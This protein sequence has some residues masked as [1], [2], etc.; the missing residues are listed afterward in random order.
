MK[1]TG[2]GYFPISNAVRHRV[3][4]E[5]ASPRR[6]SLERGFS[7]V[8]VVKSFKLIV[9]PFLHPFQTKKKPRHA[10]QPV[11]VD[12]LHGDW[13][14]PAPKPGNENSGFLLDIETSPSKRI[15][16]LEK[17]NCRYEEN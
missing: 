13:A 11:P 16:V 5:I 7:G 12:T 8:E 2:A 1:M 15:P 10:S 6:V 17:K 3:C 9:K 4:T 14:H